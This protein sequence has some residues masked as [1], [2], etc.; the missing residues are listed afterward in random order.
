MAG[1]YTFFLKNSDYLKWDSSRKKCIFGFVEDKS[2]NPSFWLLGDPF[3]RTYVA[4]HDMENQKIGLA[5]RHLDSGPVPGDLNV[6]EDDGDIFKKYIIW[7]LISAGTAIAV[8]ILICL[9]R[10]CCRKKSTKA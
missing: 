1:R 8:P 6:D 4:V 9:I 10:K 7:A 2:S 5:G 3:L